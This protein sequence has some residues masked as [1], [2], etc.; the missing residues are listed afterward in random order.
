MFLFFAEVDEV[1]DGGRDCHA[2]TTNAARLCFDECSVPR[3]NTDLFAPAIKVWP[4]GGSQ[5]ESSLCPHALD[6]RC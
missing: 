2:R 3:V 5:G 4:S 1:D 6:H